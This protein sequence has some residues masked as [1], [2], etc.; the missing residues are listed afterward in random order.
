MHPMTTASPLP[1]R[2]A[3]SDDRLLD[4]ARTRR[5][6]TDTAL[7][8]TGGDHLSALSEDPTDREL[9]H[10]VIRRQD[11]SRLQVHLDRR[12]GTVVVQDVF[13]NAFRAA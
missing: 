13:D 2:R 4:L 7:V 9:W 8:A 1:I 12:L 3:I 5:Q 10:A 11:G 6:L